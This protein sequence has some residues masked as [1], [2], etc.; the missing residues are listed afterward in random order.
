MVDY[1]KG[2]LRNSKVE[3]SCRRGILE[4]GLLGVEIPAFVDVGTS[5]F[6]DCRGLESWHFNPMGNALSPPP[7]FN[8]PH[9]EL[10]LEVARLH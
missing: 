2:D 9:P 6:V 1:G 10:E 8:V 3:E 5:G 7:L 4:C